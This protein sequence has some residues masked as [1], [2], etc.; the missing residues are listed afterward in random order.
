MKTLLFLLHTAQLA[1]PASHCTTCNTPLKWWHNIPLFSY[2]FLRGKC[3]Y[4]KEKISL[5]YPLVELVS[6]VIFIIS[7]VK[8]GDFTQALLVSFIFDL[9]LGLSV[10][11]FRYK[12]VP[13]SL[14]LSALSKKR[15]FG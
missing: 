11:D 13:D 10:I 2:I 6:M 8:L 3:S 5:Q 1:F 4:C 9:L 12:A 14:N 15:S 7:Y